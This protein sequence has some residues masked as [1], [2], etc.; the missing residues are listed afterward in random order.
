[1]NQTWRIYENL[2]ASFSLILIVILCN[3]FLPF[4]FFSRTGRVVGALDAR[5]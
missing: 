4:V 1:M 3:R 5:F 2:R